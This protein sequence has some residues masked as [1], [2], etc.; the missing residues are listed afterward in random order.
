MPRLDRPR[1][2]YRTDRIIED[3]AL[4]GWNN[5]ML[6]RAAQL[7]A[8]TVGLFLSG[9]FQTPKTADRMARALGYPVKRY[10]GP[11]VRAAQHAA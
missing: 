10:V 6:A 7:S 1:V 8:S 3:M 4:R 9:A 5:S 2:T 11:V